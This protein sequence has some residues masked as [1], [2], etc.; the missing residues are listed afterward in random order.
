[1][2][3]SVKDA[4]GATQTIKTNDDMAGNAGTPSANVLS[5]QGVGGGSALAVTVSNL[6]GTQAVSGAVSVSNLPALQPVS[7]SVS[8][9]NFPATQSVT[10]AAWPLPAGAAADAS[11]GT[12][13]TSPPTLPG[14]STGIM[15]LLR[16]VGT[17]FTSGAGIASGALRVVVASDQSAIP[18]VSPSAAY[19]ERSGTIAAGGT[20]QTLAAANPTRRFFRV[21][22]LS[23]GDLWINDKGATAVANQPSFKLVAGAM[24]ETSSCAPNAAISIF[25]ATTGQS[26]SAAEA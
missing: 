10:A 19:N 9:S 3:L 2:T 12:I 24:Y 25:G 13:G 11:L 5:V 22:N 18:A 7:G 26:F 4:S 23:T 15:G 14:S 6:P 8:V 16:W 20:S 1:M 21:M 17:L